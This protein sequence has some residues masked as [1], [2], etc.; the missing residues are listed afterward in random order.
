MV[1]TLLRRVVRLLFAIL[2][3]LQVEGLDNIPARGGAILAVNHLSII[4]S[5]LIF[6]LLERRDATS[7]VGDSY[8]KN[9]F[10]RWLV[11]AVHG[12]WINR[13]EADL[14]ALRA[15]RDYVKQGGLLGIAPEGHRSSG[16]LMEVKTGVAYLAY[17]TGAPVIPISI[18][19]TEDAL[20]RLI[21]LQRPTIHVRVGRPFELP[22]LDR[23]DRNASLQRNTDEIMCQIA[24]QLPERYHGVYAGHPR[25]LEL[26]AE[27]MLDTPRTSGI[28]ATTS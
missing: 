3:R 4:D 15:A 6:D 19:G 21:R 23:R 2:S 25:L 18:W 16:A 9:P 11:E 28:I 5:P 10:I 22:P 20:H 24:R 7:L 13:G 1:R 14:H 27:S 17:Q 12:I 8:K 26:E